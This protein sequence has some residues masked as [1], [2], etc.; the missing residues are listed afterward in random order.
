M[1]RVRSSFTTIGLASA[2]A[3]SGASG[4]MASRAVG[5]AVS[6]LFD[7][8]RK[9]EHKVQDPVRKDARLAVL[10]VGHAT[11]LVQID[12]KFILTDPVFTSTVG[13]VSKRLVEPGIDVER[14][15]N[16]DAVLVSHLHFDHL[17][18]GTLDEIQS[19]VRQLL[20]PAGGVAY[21]TDFGFPATE[22]R[23]WQ[24][25]EKDGLRV[26]AVPVDHSGYR[27]GLDAQWMTHSFT[28]YV[29]EY[30]GLKVYFGGD[31]AYDAKRFLET[32]QRFPGIDVALLPIAPIEPRDFM[33]TKHM[34]PPEAVQAFLDLGARW[35]VPIHYD[36]FVNSTDNPGDARRSLDE[37]V[38]KTRLGERKVVPLAIGE[39]RV[40]VKEGEE[41]HDLPKDEAPPP[42]APE[43]PKSSPEEKK[44][45]G[46]DIPDDDKLD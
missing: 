39:Q 14:L 43:K 29:I 20:M 19:K 4:C 9:V 37:A 26:T 8:P 15:P 38:K 40:F 30:H 23:T 31:T 28:G 22:L 33:R 18:L 16:L 12:D 25:W 2:L 24:F 34:D 45:P 21:L 36:T 11:A 41:H 35:M 7:S 27:Y 1:N 44:E 17:S 46:G 3:V 13:Q 42:P 32:S 6:S 10:W 5:R